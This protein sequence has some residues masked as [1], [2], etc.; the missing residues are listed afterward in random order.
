MSASD[1]GDR[2]YY[3]CVIVSLGYCWDHRWDIRDGGEADCSS[4]LLYVLWECG[5]LPEK[6]TWG[7]TDTLRSQ[8]EPFGFKFVAADNTK[9]APRGVALLR[10]GH[11]AVS[12]GDGTVAQASINELGT[13]RGGQPGDQTG[14]ETKVSKDPKN[15]LWWIYPPDMPAYSKPVQTTPNEK[16]KKVFYFGQVCKGKTGTAVLMFQCVANVRFGYSLTLDGSCGPA[17]DKAIREIQAKLG[18]EQDGSCGPA[19]WTAI[20]AA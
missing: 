16:G 14:L 4:L 6:P 7:N 19:T 8:L 5:Y 15:W 13:V 18:L 9:T 2:M 1:I 17:T 10:K 20:L 11:V 3:W 12:M